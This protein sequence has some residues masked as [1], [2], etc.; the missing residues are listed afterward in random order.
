MK[1]VTLAHVA[2]AADVHKATA[3]RALNR[4]PRISQAT[5]ERVERAAQKLGY[6][7]NHLLAAWM[8]SRRRQLPV[9]SA[10]LAYV[11]GHPTRYAWRPPATDLPNF[12]PGAR[13]RAI[14]AGYSVED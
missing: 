9:A 6:K 14:K 2:E 8:S 13:E 5:R 4:D 11:T 7:V 10:V 12:H 3:A 1:P